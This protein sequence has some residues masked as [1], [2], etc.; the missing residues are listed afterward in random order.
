M[1]KTGH[2]VSPKEELQI[3]FLLQNTWKTPQHYHEYVILYTNSYFSL[4]R[5]LFYWSFPITFFQNDFVDFSVLENWRASTCKAQ[6]CCD[7]FPFAFD[8]F[9]F[10]FFSIYFNLFL[11]SS[12]PNTFIRSFQKPVRISTN[13]FFIIFLFSLVLFF[14]KRNEL[15][16][17]IFLY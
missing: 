6:F 13:L 4:S 5:F 12:L 9:I 1:P 10:T 15:K 16:E 2:L 3:F 11:K 14:F 8:E 17:N 7:F